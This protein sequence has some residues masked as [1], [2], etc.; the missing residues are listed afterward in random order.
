[1]SADS[2]DFGITTASK[3]FKSR[4]G[5]TEIHFDMTTLAAIIGMAYD[6]GYQN[7]KIDAVMDLE[8]TNRH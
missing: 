7:G 8:E 4:G 5:H 1:M 6:T 2:I 3:I